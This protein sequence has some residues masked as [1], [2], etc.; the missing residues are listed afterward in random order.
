MSRFVALTFSSH[1]QRTVLGNRRKE[2]GVV[3]GVVVGLPVQ[4]SIFS[5][6]GWGA[7]YKVASD[8]ERK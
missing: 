3:G 5:I 6:V 8:F 7:G 1:G 2:P 4:V